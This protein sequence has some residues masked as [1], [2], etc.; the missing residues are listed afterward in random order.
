MF[1]NDLDHFIKES[2]GKLL[3][4]IIKGTSPTAKFMV[5][6]R[7]HRFYES[8]NK[9]IQQLLPTGIINHLAGN[10][11][12]EINSRKFAN[13]TLENVQPMSL[14]HLEAAFVIWLVSL[15]FPIAAFIV[16][17][18]FRLRDFIVFKITFEAYIRASKCN[19][20]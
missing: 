2:K 9:E 14:K 15:L 1:S 20:K 10:L 16:E 6:P 13:L 19:G 5:F 8:F 7:N 12:N 4:R 18:I 17:W 3:G 11:G